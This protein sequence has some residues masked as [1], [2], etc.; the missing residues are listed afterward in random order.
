[1]Q[2]VSLTL[3]EITYG[4][5]SVIISLNSP[6][7]G[8]T[9]I[10]Y[11]DR[12]L[13][14]TDNS[15]ASTDFAVAVPGSDTALTGTMEFTYVDLPKRYTVTLD[16]NG[17]S[18]G[19]A[20]MTKT[21]GVT[22]WLDE[23][24][25]PTRTGYA[26][27]GWST[28]QIGGTA[29]TSYTANADTTFYARWTAMSYIVTLPE[30]PVGYVIAP[31][32]GSSSPVAHGG[33]YSFTLTLSD[34]FTNGMIVVRAN[35]KA[36][37]AVNGVYTI[38]NITSDQAVTVELPFWTA[39]AN[40]FTAGPNPVARSAGEVWLFRR[41]SRVGDGKL[42]VYDAMGNFIRK[43]DISD[44]SRGDQRRRKVGSWDLRDAKGR[45]VSEGTYL[46]RDTLTTFDGRAEK[47]SVILGV[48]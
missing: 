31:R 14:S 37:T 24:A 34:E 15:V 27:S 8:D 21:Q 25:P 40:K 30:Y 23:A 45:L 36:L 4:E 10:S 41:G 28:R 33:S 22:L 19:T 16:P 1:L 46:F 29:V 43:I 7:F 35:G 6:S 44:K 32:A 11:A 18:G 38:S 9:A 13:I 12:A 47:V 42:T 48:R 26:F 20:A 2:R 5:W 3:R 39:G 17:G